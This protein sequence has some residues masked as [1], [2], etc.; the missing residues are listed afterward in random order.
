[1]DDASDM[2][3]LMPLDMLPEDDES[4][5]DAPPRNLDR[6]SEK[7]EFEMGH[8]EVTTYVYICIYRCVCTLHDGCGFDGCRRKQLGALL[9]QVRG[10]EVGY[11]V[12]HCAG[13]VY[14]VGGEGSL[15]TTTEHWQHQ[16]H[17]CCMRHMAD[18]RRRLK[19]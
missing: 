15:T 18:G 1:M 12:Q 16:Y 9:Q 6:W 2:A 7:R 4:L 8:E 14:V 3:L 11:E 5:L 10:E 17:R 13:R 19:T